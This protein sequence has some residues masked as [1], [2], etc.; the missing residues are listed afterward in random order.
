MKTY[1]QLLSLLM[2]TV[3]AGCSK[4]KDNPTFAD[5]FK[6]QTW[7]GLIHYNLAPSIVLEPF[8]I[9]FNGNNTYSWE[10]KSGKSEGTYS[11]NE[12]DKKVTIN[13]SSSQSVTFF[14][15]DNKTFTATA[16]SAGIN[17]TLNSCELNTAPNTD[18][19]NT[20]WKSPITGAI[21]IFKTSGTLEHVIPYNYTRSG[22]LF[23][24]TYALGGAQLY[25]IINQNRLRGMSYQGSNPNTMDYSK[26]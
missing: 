6:N 13:L 22:P 26:Q 25:F 19:V 5:N 1:L 17:W 12:T 16:Y 23:K 7:S 8:F 21:I 20:T 15:N 24:A 18:V 11:L 10:D 2:A 3:L 14:V 9:T 4:D